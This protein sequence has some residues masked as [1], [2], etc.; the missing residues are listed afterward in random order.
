[1]S[2]I[3]MFKATH[4][5]KDGFSPEVQLAIVSSLICSSLGDVQVLNLEFVG[6]SRLYTMLLAIYN[7]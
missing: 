1:M 4:N 7:K 3:N 6:T 2:A 5:S